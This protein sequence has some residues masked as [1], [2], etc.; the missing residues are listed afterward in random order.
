MANGKVTFGLRRQQLRVGVWCGRKGKNEKER[1]R[2]RPK[3][4]RKELH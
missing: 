4:Q 3:I 2:E 1:K